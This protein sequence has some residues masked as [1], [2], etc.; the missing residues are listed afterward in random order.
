MAIVLLAG[1][2]LLM[3]SLLRVISVDPGFR[4]DHLLSSRFRCPGNR[5]IKDGAGEHLRADHA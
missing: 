5:Y 4:T 1:A 3:K 2:G